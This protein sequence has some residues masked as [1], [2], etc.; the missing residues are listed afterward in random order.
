MNMVFD[1]VDD[2]DESVS[3]E[4]L[5]VKAKEG[6]RYWFIGQQHRCSFCPSY[7][8]KPPLT[9]ADQQSCTYSSCR[10]KAGRYWKRVFQPILSFLVASTLERCAVQC[11]ERTEEGSEDL[12]EGGEEGESLQSDQKREVRRTCTEEWEGFVWVCCLSN[13]GLPFPFFLAVSET[14]RDFLGG[15]W[16]SK[17]E[18]HC[19]LDLKFGW[20]LFS[21]FC[22]CCREWM[23]RSK[24]V[25]WWASIHHVSAQ[26]T[27]VLPQCLDLSPSGCGAGGAHS[28]KGW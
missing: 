20:L 4:R 26:S 19:R 3:T 12:D 21:C 27:W 8:F 28:R 5:I 17:Y 14:C 25:C 16:R 15:D 22:Q 9:T 24:C 10:N 18:I 11:N 7:Y 1:D 23:S 13:V 6:A 2:D